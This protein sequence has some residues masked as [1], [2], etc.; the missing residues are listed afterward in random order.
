MLTGWPHKVSRKRK[1]LEE[2]FR[3][4]LEAA[5]TGMLMTD[6]TGTIVLVNAQIEKL[7]GYPRNELL[8]QRIEVLVPER[9]RAHHPGLREAFSRN[10]AARPMGAG[11]ELYGLRKDGTEVPIEIGLNPLRTPDGEFVLSSVV[12]ISHRQ[13]IDRMRRGFISTVSH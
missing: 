13:E 5:P 12:D 3:L 9:F 7:F 2:Q 4:A 1:Q 6:H 11:R 8:G 10:P